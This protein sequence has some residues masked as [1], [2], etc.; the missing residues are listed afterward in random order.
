M[1]RLFP[2]RTPIT[3]SQTF[4]AALLVAALLISGCAVT[5]PKR[6]G[7]ATVDNRQ[8]CQGRG[9]QYQQYEN[10]A[11]CLEAPVHYRDETAQ[12]LG[13]RAKTALY[14][15]GLLALLSLL[16]DDKDD[17]NECG[18]TYGLPRPCDYPQ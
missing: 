2:L 9:G 15:A 13:E 18:F 17:N 8:T 7:H 4:V 11:T 6:N 10:A 16:I 3:H 14:S 5:D 12:L 1:T